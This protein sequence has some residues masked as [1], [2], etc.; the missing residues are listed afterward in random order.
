MFYW[1]ISPC[2]CLNNII[3]SSMDKITIRKITTSDID[4]LQKISRQTFYET[5]SASNTEKD[6]NK[7]LEEGF[8]LEK[9]TAELNDPNSVFYFAELQGNVIGYIKLN[10]G[11]AQTELKEENALEIE[12]IYVLKAFQ[13]NKVGQLLYEKAI[14][15]A[16]DS[17]VDFIWLGVWEENA[18]AIKFYKKNGFVEFDKNIFKLGDDEQTDIMMKLKM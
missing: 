1:K 12:R 16:R 4:Q 2:I 8:A 7:Y 17:N 11:G 13:G 15:I 18:S 6:M 14:Q 3:Q 5:F 10:Q 9:L